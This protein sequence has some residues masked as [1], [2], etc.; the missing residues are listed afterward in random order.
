MSAVFKM[1][2]FQ[3]HFQIFIA[4]FHFRNMNMP[5]LCRRTAKMPHIGVF[6]DNLR[7]CLH[8]IHWYLLESERWGCGHLRELCAS[9]SLSSLQT[10]IA[11]NIVTVVVIQSWPALVGP[12]PALGPEQL[13]TL[14]V[15]KQ[16]LCSSVSSQGRCFLR[17]VISEWKLV[18]ICLS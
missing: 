11:I 14:L 15:S 16:H 10:V 12:L 7:I 13:P 2:C 18:V 9:L 4:L 1:L 8:K 6:Q 17:L 3:G 5:L